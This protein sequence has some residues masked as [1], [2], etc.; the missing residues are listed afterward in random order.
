MRLEEI[1][2]KLT[3]IK[4]RGY[5]KTLRNGSTGV[6]Y[7]LETL[8]G[9]KENNVS[10]P[11]LGEIE[12]KTY[13][14]NHTGLITLFTFNRNAWLM[15]PLDAVKKYGS[16]DKSG[17]IGLYYTMD[18]K[19]NSNG[20]FLSVEDDFV[21][22]R[23]IDGNVIA[24]WELREIEERF[25][26]KVKNILLVKAK[27]EKRKDIEYFLFNRARLLSGGI[28]KS[29]LKKQFQNRQLLLDLR[30]YDRGTRARNHGTGFR[31]NVKDLENFY[32]KVEKIEF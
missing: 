8:L 18:I 30:L 20:L 26:K 6:G 14:E 28:T 22:V 29:I 4:K 23:S 9:I 15:K 13:R 10:S 12:L 17:R 11:D 1:K 7:T 16:K 19:P 24:R 27:V 32:K 2:K 25:S 21:S 3:K 31:I 5:V